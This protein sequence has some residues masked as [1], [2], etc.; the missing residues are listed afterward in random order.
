MYAILRHYLICGKS[1]ECLCYDG[2][3]GYVLT[4]EEAKERVNQL[5]KMGYEDARYEK[6]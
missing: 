1:V 6:V 3:M 5:H 2:G 4:E